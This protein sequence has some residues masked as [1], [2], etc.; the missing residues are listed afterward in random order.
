MRSPLPLTE[1]WLSMSLLD[2]EQ[3]NSLS[4]NQSVIWETDRD[5]ERLRGSNS[6]CRLQVW[7]RPSTHSWDRKVVVYV[8]SG[9]G[10]HVPGELRARHISLELLL[11]TCNVWLMWS[12][13]DAREH[14]QKDMAPLS[15]SPHAFMASALTRSD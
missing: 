7:W 8:C 6:P 1:G 4:I 14:A 13:T 5:C 11:Y 15:A 9:V 12:N 2:W 3:D 10:V